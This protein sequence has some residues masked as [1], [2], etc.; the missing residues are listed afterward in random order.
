MVLI[1]RSKSPKTCSGLGFANSRHPGSELLH[2]LAQG[3]GDSANKPGRHFW[4]E[5]WRF[6]ATS[7]GIHERRKIGLNINARLNSVPQRFT[8]GLSLSP[9]E[10]ASDSLTTCEAKKGTPNNDRRHVCDLLALLG[11]ITNSRS[12]RGR[13]ADADQ[14]ALALRL[15]APDEH[16]HVGALAT[17]VGVHLSNTRY[18][19]A[20]RCCRGW[21]GSWYA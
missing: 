11:G 15:N 1:Q 16:R 10:G 13:C 6:P 20:R 21:S 3:L 4:P 2:N 7:R 14:F 9:S 5:R 18:C 8:P 12:H 17:T 19:S